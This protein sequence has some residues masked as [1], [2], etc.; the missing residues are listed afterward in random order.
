MA[1]KKIVQRIGVGACP[2]CQN[3]GFDYQEGADPRDAERAP[4]VCPKCGWKGIVY[5]LVI[6]PHSDANKDS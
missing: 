1:W 5:E 3:P 4:I 6:I 2:E